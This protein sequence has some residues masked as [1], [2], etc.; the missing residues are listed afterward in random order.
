MDNNQRLAREIMAHV[1]GAD[2]ITALNHCTTRLRLQVKDP[3]KFD[4]EA[5]KKISGVLDVIKSMGGFQIIVGNNVRKVFDVIVAEYNVKVDAA[6]GRVSANWFQV[7]LNVLSDIMGPALPAIVGAG[8]FSAIATICT[9]CG[10]S[11]ESSTYQIIYA[12]S[13]VP[14][15]FLPFILAYTCARHW[16]LNPVMTIF[17]TG[18]MFHPSFSAL[19]DAGGKIDLFGLPVTATSYAFTFIPI[20]L[21][22]WAMHYVSEFLEEHIP[23]SVRYVMVPFLTMAI[24][25]P[26]ALCI[27]GPIGTWIG[28]IV[29]G[30][31]GMINSKVPWLTVLVVGFL[32][33]F[34]VLTGS[35]LALTPLFIVGFS[36]LGYDSIVF[37]AFIGMNF[38]QFAVSLAVFLKT[39]NKN[40]K[41]TSF[42]TGL[43]AFLTGTTEPTLYGI[44][45]RLKKPLIATVIG[46]TANAIYCAIF[47]VKE[48]AM[49]A[50]SFFTMVNFIDP[51]GSNNFVYA[52]GAVVVTIVVTFAATW[53]L[54]WDESIFNSDED[55]AS[56]K[57]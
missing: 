10:M 51:N 34:L 5:I 25:V 11:T 26:I 46:S 13:Q 48:Y 36:T 32:A 9:L 44:C 4:L 29:N 6:G 43:T 52:I 27:T 53:I 3:E 38:S 37:P 15:Y 57:N 21:T 22:C 18:V 17:L 23:D 20:I 55:T 42:S 24:M 40:L 8:L 12:V 49:G 35:H 16:K 41:Q 2:N 39:K 14:F 54:G 31:V 28:A 1:G 30:F 33:P 47:G 45:I 7:L 56:A 19:V 50:P